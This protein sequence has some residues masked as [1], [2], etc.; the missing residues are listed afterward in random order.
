MPPLPNGNVSIGQ[1]RAEW[2]KRFIYVTSGWYRQECLQIC[3]QYKPH[4]L[5]VTYFFNA[6]G[7]FGF[8]RLLAVLNHPS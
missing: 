7:L 1:P 4:D 8:A 5:H 3:M 6:R 2:I